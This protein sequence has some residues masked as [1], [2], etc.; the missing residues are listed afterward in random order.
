M[1]SLST[2]TLSAKDG[3]KVGRRVIQNFTYFTELG[4]KLRC[5]L[6][7]VE[8]R[9]PA[10][11]ISANDSTPNMAEPGVLRSMDGRRPFMAAGTPPPHGLYGG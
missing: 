1:G 7:V 10:S 6:A 5:G 4:D 3:Q 2:S 8:R 11:A 9:S